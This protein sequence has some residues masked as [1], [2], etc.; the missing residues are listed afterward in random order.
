MG[1]PDLIVVV[2]KQAYIIKG[3][4]YDTRFQAI[5]NAVGKFERQ[6]QEID[7]SRYD[8]NGKLY[9][10]ADEHWFPEDVEKIEIFRL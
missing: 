7:K 3:T 8:E 4:E 2:N 9:K 10:E 6:Q 5:R 1:N